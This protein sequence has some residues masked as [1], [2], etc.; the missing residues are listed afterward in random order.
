MKFEVEKKIT[1]KTTM[2]SSELVMF[3]KGGA[4]KIKLN[5][6]DLFPDL[7]CTS[8]P[9]VEIQV[10]LEKSEQYRFNHVNKPVTAHMTEERM[11]QSQKE[12]KKELDKEIL[13]RKGPNGKN[14]NIR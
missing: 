2:D 12:F 7:I 9:E 1:L 8:N 3:N 5:L 11:L 14:F 4:H 10:Q 6:K 13:K